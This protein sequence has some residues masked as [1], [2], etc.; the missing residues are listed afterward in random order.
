MRKCGKS[1]LGKYLRENIVEADS[2]GTENLIIDGGWLLYQLPRTSDMTFSERAIL[3]LHT[4]R[5]V[6]KIQWRYMAVTITQQKAHE[7][8]EVYYLYWT[9][10]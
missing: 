8:I 9:M 7:K 6:V 5:L 10:S 1:E 3:D 2:C 4:T